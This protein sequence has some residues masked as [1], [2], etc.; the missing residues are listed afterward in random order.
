MAEAHPGRD[1]ATRIGRVGVWSNLDR[2]PAAA[3]RAFVAEIE[4]LGYGAVWFPE[5]VGGKEAFSLATLLLSSSRRIVVA[6][7]IA[8]IWARDAMAMANGARALAEAFPG[9]FLLGV[10]VSHRPSVELR[11]HHYDHPLREMRRYLDAMDAARYTGPAPSDPAPR[12]LAA[13][14]ER[15]LR[16]AAERGAGAHPYFV[17]VEHTSL[18]RAALGAGLIL[19]V[20]Q[21]VVLER[22][23]AI[24]RRVARETHT[25]RYLALENYA[26]N[27]RRLG[28]RDA[29]L[30]DGGSDRLV[31][32]IVAWGDLEAVRRR[33]KEHLDRGADHVCVQVLR[34]DPGTPPST[35]LRALAPALLG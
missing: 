9:R 4:A 29:D 10:G 6:T 3:L 25:K 34:A 13:L 19:A 27:L 12:V 32:A 22:D 24:A 8:S 1:V 7:G 21:A 31:D 28:W 18:A 5:T 33:V 14:G 11:G 20:E 23:P 2:I 30:A 16:L 15:M 17:P 26:N 35:E